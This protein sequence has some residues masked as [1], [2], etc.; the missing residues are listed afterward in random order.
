MQRERRDLGLLAGGSLVSVAGDSAAMIALLLELRSHGV[1]WVSAALGA[2]LLPFVL[3]ASFSGRIV[4]RVDNRRL[5]VMGLA[6]QAAVAVPLAFARSPWLVVA[7]F[8]A[9]NAVATLVRPASSAM[10]PVLAGEDN[11]TKGFTWIATGVGI[12]WIVGPAA[13]GLL[14]SASGV[15]ATLLVDAGTFL[16]TAAAC[17]LLSATRKPDGTTDEE[18]NQH[19]GLRIIRSDT[20]LFLSVATTSIAV[21]CAVVDNVAAPFRFVEQLATSS[22]GYGAY[23]ALWGVGGIIGSQLPRRLNGSTLPAALAIGNGLS[24]L[25][26]VGIGLAPSLGLALGA[27]ALG[28]FGN[29]ISNVAEAALL[30]ARVKTEQRGRVYASAAALIQTGIGV[31][32]V[33]GAPLVAALG[34][35]HAMISAGGLAALLS[36]VTLIWTMSRNGGAEG[37]R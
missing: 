8:F 25:G 26:I 10:V 1:G 19:G 28:G 31:G 13:G 18:E 30:A 24:G 11:A 34:A 22:T 35:G 23:L 5:L 29:G 14:T 6:G 36:G 3:F 37:A 15:T 12:G 32:T 33:A 20:V 16:V 27:S 21:A 9:L 4:D 7:L 17:G 2:E